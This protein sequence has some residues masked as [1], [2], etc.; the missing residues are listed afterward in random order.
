MDQFLSRPI[1]SLKGVGAYYI[2]RLAKLGITSVGELLRHFPK[3][4]DDFSTFVTIGEI[5][6]PG[7]YSVLCRVEAIKTRKS[8]RRRLF[9]IDARVSDDTGSMAAVW[10][11][12]S[13]L[14]RSI[15][16]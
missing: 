2:K 6:E 8:F 13:Y 11:G 12:Q 10:F 1:D 5:K 15:P 14:V 3:R 16:Q 7:T 4:Y 9:V